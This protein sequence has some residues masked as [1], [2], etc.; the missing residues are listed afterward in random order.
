MVTVPPV[1]PDV[2]HLRKDPVIAYMP[3]NFQKPYPFQPTVAIDVGPVLDKIVAMLD[4]HVSQF[5]EWLPYNGRHLEKIPSDKGERKEL[6]AD[7]VRKRLREQAHRFT[8]QLV[9]R[10]GEQR[11]KAVKFAEA[12]EACEYGSPLNEEAQKRLFSSAF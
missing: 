5:Y 12:F 1:V 10:Y 4:C 11:G 9:E 2:P 3:D 8:T 7:H 6:L